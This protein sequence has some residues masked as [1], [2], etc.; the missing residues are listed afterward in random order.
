M[1]KLVIIINVFIIALIT[2]VNLS[3][4]SYADFDDAAAKKE[5]EKLIQEQEKTEQEKVEQK[6]TEKS[7][8]NYLATLSVDDYRIV[9]EFD[10]EKEDFK[11]EENI[12]NDKIKI[13]AKAEDEKATVKGAGTVELK[14]GE[15]KIKIDVTAE[16]GNTRSYYIIADFGE[17][18]TENAAVTE[19]NN[20]NELE[21]TNVTYEKKNN[22]EQTNKNNDSNSIMIWVIAIVSVIVIFIVIKSFSKKSKKGRR[23]Q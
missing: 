11:I 3:W 4:A 21:N 18:E 9:P 20:A 19:K 5:T 15:N 6:T 12:K 13:N 17:E 2:T 16:N 1:K 23:Y 22:A 8:N 10:K 7:S 14:K